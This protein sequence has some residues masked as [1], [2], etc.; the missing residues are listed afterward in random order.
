MSHICK[1]CGKRE[2]NDWMPKCAERLGRDQHCFTCDFW[3]RKL[4]N[5]DKANVARIKGQ[6]Y[7]ICKEIDAP[8]DWKGHGGR[9][10]RIRFSD[11]RE[12]ITTNLMHQG[13]IP[14][15]WKDD[16][17]DNAVFI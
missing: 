8:D 10:F 15:N 7:T 3:Q 2:K 4:D 12:V 13:E 5:I 6:H 14:E 1:R 17:P 11:G 9:E 16:L